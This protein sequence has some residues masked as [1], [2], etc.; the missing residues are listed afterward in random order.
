MYICLVY[1]GRIP[2]ER[3]G[4]TQRVVHWLARDLLRMGHRVALAAHPGS[5]VAGARMLH[6]RGLGKLL[7]LVPAEAD[8]VHLHDDRPVMD[9]DRPCLK[10]IHG[11]T[12][13]LDEHNACFVSRDHARRHGRETFVYNG[14]PADECYFS[15]EKSDRLLF[16]ARINRPGKNI[17]RALDLSRAHGV[18]LDVAGGNRLDLLRRSTVRREGAFRKSLA[19]GAR[20]HGMVGG[21][22]KARLLAHARALLFPIRWD[23]PFGLVVVEA[24]L[25]GTPVI[26]TDFGAMRE[27]VHPD[28]GYICSTDA[29][30]TAAISG[31]ATM[32]AERCRAYAADLFTTSTT[33][34]GYLDLYERTISGERLP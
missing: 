26:T 28:V 2:V 10:T 20:F 4:G 19:A 24:L 33:A 29:E 32:S 22:E 21:W 11:N 13:A 9:L 25:A 30:F 12:A 27:I 23:E 8:I 16:F 18:T 34:R 31:V 15:G 1:D 7:S 14:V 3:Y 5:Y 6:G 17:T